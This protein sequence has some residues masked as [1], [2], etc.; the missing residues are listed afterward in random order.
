MILSQHTKKIVFSKKIECFCGEGV[1]IWDKSQWGSPANTL[2]IYNELLHLKIIICDFSLN[3][4]QIKL[5][6]KQINDCR[7]SFVASALHDIRKY[8]KQILTI[9]IKQLMLDWQTV[10]VFSF[11]MFKLIFKKLNIF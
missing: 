10:F 9:L 5:I 2:C 6:K 1:N 4:Y 11:Y 7:I 8:K 3:P